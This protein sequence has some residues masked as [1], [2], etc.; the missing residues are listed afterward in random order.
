MKVL[1]Y[2]LALGLAAAT[3][4]ATAA[5][6]KPASAKA[7]APKTKKKGADKGASA[8]EAAPPLS[9]APLAPADAP[10][11]DALPPGPQNIYLEEARTMYLNFQFEGIIAKLEFALAVRGVTPEQKIEIFK[12]MAQTHA[13]S[14]DA[15]K[16]E[17][18][19]LKLLEIKPD[20]DLGATASPKLRGYLASARKTYRAQQAVVLHHEPPVSTGTGATTTVDIVVTSGVDRVATMTLHYRPRGAESGFSQTQMT[21]GEH[22][23]FSANVPNVFK[24]PAGKRTIE[25]FVRARD[26]SG[27]FLAGVGDEEKPLEM[28]VETVEP[29]S[30]PFYKSWAFWVP[31]TAVVAAGVAA[32]F[33]FKRDAQT[34]PGNL[35]V[36]RLK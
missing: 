19:F 5:G 27:A 3:P 20:F 7:K 2:V 31:V 4:P 29:P 23:A 34:Q 11:R 13:A 21:A 1:P 24:G 28:I 18:A 8:G 35:G 32:P 30:K 33:V 6:K 22:G 15:P 25:Y 26:A 17:E 16:A 12:L 9:P 36:E 10:T 14:D